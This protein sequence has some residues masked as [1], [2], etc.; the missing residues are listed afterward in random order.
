M[1]HALLSPSSSS[2]WLSCPGSV[3]MES[4]V[5]AGSVEEES[6]SFAEEGTAAHFL[7]EQSLLEGVKPSHFKGRTIV[8][9]D[10]GALWL[11]D[12]DADDPDFLLADCPQFFVGQDMVDFVSQYTDY[13]Q[14]LQTHATEF[15]IEQSLDIS[16]IT[17]EVGASGTA[18]AVL[19]L[20]N[21]LI[22]CDLKYGRGV[23]V[24]A[25]DNTQLLIYALAAYQ[26]YSLFCDIEQIRLVIVQPR[27]GGTSEW[28]ISV[29]K[30][31]DIMP[32]IQQ[33][34]RAA[35]N[36][37]TLSDTLEPGEECNLDAHL[38]PS[39]KACRFCDAKAV[40]PALLKNVMDTT[41]G[42]F[43]SVDIAQPIEP[44]VR[45]QI[46][47][48]GA[49]DNTV[50]GNL[51]SAVPLI[52][53]WCKAIRSR[54]EAELFKGHE[55]PGWKLVEG[56]KGQRRWGDNDEA[57]ELLKGMRLKTDE[58]YDLK[59]ISP[60]TAE[61]LK[62]EK[63]IGPRQWKKVEALISQPDGKPSVAPESDRRPALVVSP[64]EDD[65]EEVDSTT[66]PFAEESFD[67]L[68]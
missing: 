8:N 53:S 54:A 16:E 46:G 42:D 51:L 56:R 34:A 33:H 1:P 50:V 59:L 37:I 63:I 36:L 15:Q 58:M 30:A 5:R 55:V 6:S 2:R 52:E 20:G 26:E 44:Q 27:K 35:L 10:T 28:D 48:K 29:E 67:D 23:Q 60:A 12:V 43:D 22:I 9:H 19:V 61:K 38:H 25:E 3:A 17:G 41:M 7:A 62:K 66:E 31:L 4:R 32:R 47:P 21:E 49:Y 40:C 64:P 68:I 45:E 57:E 14:D 13:V 65:F 18:D 11:N 39:E 24:T